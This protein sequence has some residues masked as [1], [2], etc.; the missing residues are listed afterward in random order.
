MNI[1]NVRKEYDSLNLKLKK[2]N[3]IFKST[4]GRNRATYNFKLI[5]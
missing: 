1:K 5:K 4:F 2:N 3:Y